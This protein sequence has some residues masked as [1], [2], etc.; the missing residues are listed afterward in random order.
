MNSIASRLAKG[1]MWISA[2]RGLVNLL[3]FISTIVLA[4]LLAPS[5]F[6]VVAIGNTLLAIVGSFTALPLSQALIQHKAP[7][8]DHFHTAWTLGALK[9]ILLGVVFAIFAQPAASFYNEPH[10]VNVM[11]ALAF[12]MCLSGLG[13][14]RRI[15]LQKS[16][17]FWQ[18][19]MLSVSQKLFAVATAIVVAY[20]FRS[21]WALVL[22]IIAG[23]IA[24]IA[25]S[26][27]AL[28]F[29]PKI[30]FV[31]YRDLLSFSMW[32]TFS[33]VVNTLNWRFDQL[34]IGKLLGR[35][36]VGY[37]TVGDTLA[38]MPT[39]EATQ[40]LTQTL[41]PAFSQLNGNKERLRQGYRRAQAVVTAVALP[42]GV[43]MALVAYPMVEFFMGAKW[44]AAVPVIQALASIYALQ[45]LGSLAQPL[46][47]SLGGTRML[48]IRDTQLFAIRLPLIAAG[49]Y[50]G[51]L[52][53]VLIAR[54]FTGTIAI[55]FNFFIVRS[56]IGIPVLAQILSNARS[57]TSCVLM[58]LAVYSAQDVGMFLQAEFGLLP[59]LLGLVAIGGGVY[60][61]SMFMMWWFAGR[62]IG[63]ETELLRVVTGTWAR[64][65][66]YR[67]AR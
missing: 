8:A 64:F 30:R 45:T 20:F 31:H 43:G 26:Y 42:L 38:V 44:L 6:G 13:N 40:P 5:D 37:Y 17:V 60:L 54:M 65:E 9:G 21:Y 47:L 41:F 16:L 12:S 25:I 7:T 27:T 28:P 55:G 36:E 51:G 63:P 11:Y 66:R 34:L 39:R 10:L 46:G 18:D 56:L 4:R 24:S 1:S 23:Q 53:G 48:F 49:L 59:R 19:F 67:L 62:P 35:T 57:L 61:T 14:P 50:F 52:H 58:G 15:M 33:Q 2:A 3:G 29:L 22:S 32:L